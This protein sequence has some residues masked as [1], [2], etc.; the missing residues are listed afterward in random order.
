MKIRIAVGMV[1]GIMV[2]VVGGAIS[3]ASAYTVTC[4]DA[5]FNGTGVQKYVQ[6]G[7]RWDLNL[8]DLEIAYTVDMSA[9]TPSS[10][11]TVWTSVGVAKT[12]PD[13]RAWLSSSVNTTYYK[14]IMAGWNVD[15]R[16]PDAGSYL[17]VAEASTPSVYDI[18]LHFSKTDVS[19]TALMTGYVNATNREVK[20]ELNGDTWTVTIDNGDVYEVPLAAIEGG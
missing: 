13:E 5:S 10:Q 17:R 4:P 1:V 18:V 3:T 2:F 20:A 7:E 9:L 14:N 12:L 16:S 15:E 19:N 6:L 8:G 11:S